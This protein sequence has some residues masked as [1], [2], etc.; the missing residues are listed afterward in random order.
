MA[1]RWSTL[2]G[3]SPLGDRR[4]IRGGSPSPGHFMDRGRSPLSYGR[5]SAYSSHAGSP[6]PDEGKFMG[7]GGINQTIQQLAGGDLFHHKRWGMHVPDWKSVIHKHLVFA[8]LYTT[9]MNENNY[10]LYT[11]QQLP[12]STLQWLP[13]IKT[14]SLQPSIHSLNSLAV[15]EKHIIFSLTSFAH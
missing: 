1:D 2:R 4:G 10:A 12:I 14:D 9:P 11:I 15:D 3:G 7:S 6:A 8:I 5:G 13:Y